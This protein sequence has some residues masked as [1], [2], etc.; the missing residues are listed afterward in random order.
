MET[1]T[2]CSKNLLILLN[3]APLSCPAKLNAYVPPSKYTNI[4][5]FKVYQETKHLSKTQKLDV[6]EGDIQ[7]DLN[8]WKVED[9]FRVFPSDPNM[10]CPG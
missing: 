2:K 5:C 6:L 9:T 10:Y 8:R 3:V 1:M 7:Y 4:Y